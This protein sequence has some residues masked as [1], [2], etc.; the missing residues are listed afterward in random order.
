MPNVPSKAAENTNYHPGAIPIRLR[1]QGDP[2]QGDRRKWSKFSEQ[3]L[4]ALKNKDDLVTKIVAKYA[5]AKSQA[6]RDVDA[7]L[8]GRQI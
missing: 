2:S 8:Q 3:E 4:S 6:Q 1:D 5:L 7:L